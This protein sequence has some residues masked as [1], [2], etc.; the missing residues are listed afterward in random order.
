MAELHRNNTDPDQAGVRRDVTAEV[1]ERSRSGLMIP[2]IVAL[3]GLVLF[4]V[5]FTRFRPGA[6]GESASNLAAT[7]SSQQAQQGRVAN[8]SDHANGVYP[9]ER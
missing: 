9:P 4:V 3:M 1:S 6:T 5:L 7:Q 8:G 2:T